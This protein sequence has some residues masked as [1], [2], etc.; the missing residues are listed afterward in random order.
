[1]ISVRFVLNLN[2]ITKEEA[3]RKVVRYKYFGFIF[4]DKMMLLFKFMENTLNRQKIKEK[5]QL[6]FKVPRESICIYIALP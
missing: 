3:D 2:K 1:M 6:I 5:I 4:K